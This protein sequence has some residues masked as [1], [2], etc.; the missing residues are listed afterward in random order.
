MYEQPD[1][2]SKYKRRD[3]ILEKICYCHYGKMIRSGGKMA[4]IENENDRRIDEDNNDTEELDDEG[5]LPNSHLFLPNL[6]PFLSDFF[7]PILEP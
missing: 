5:W 3:D 4:N 1:I 2:L 6:A 7:C